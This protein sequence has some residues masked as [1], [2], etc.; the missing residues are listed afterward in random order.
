MKAAAQ[1]RKVAHAGARVSRSAGGEA[2]D[3]QAQIDH[4]REQISQ[5]RAHIREVEA[6]VAAPRPNSR[7]VLPPMNAD[8]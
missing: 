6:R 7:D 5:L 1:A 2:D 3:V 4:N 8:A